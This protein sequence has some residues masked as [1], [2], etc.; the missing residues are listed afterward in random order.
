MSLNH[1]PCFHSYFVLC[2]FL[3]AHNYYKKDR[4]FE[5]MIRLMVHARDDLASIWR[6][7]KVDGKTYLT[8]KENRDSTAT[9]TAGWY[10][11]VP[12][13]GSRDSESNYLAT[14]DDFAKAMPVRAEFAIRRK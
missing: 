4:K 7:V 1:G 2:R 10:V 11:A 3:S 6:F 14:T 5:G 8:V 12:P 9:D 13:D